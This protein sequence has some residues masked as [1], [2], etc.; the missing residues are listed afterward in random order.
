VL[1]ACPRG[2]PAARIRVMLVHMPAQVFI[3][4]RRDD[5]AGHAGRLYEGLR[6]AYGEDN[7]FKDT[8]GSGL[9]PGTV[10]PDAL[11]RKLA[12][13][14]VVLCVIGPKWLRELKQRDASECDWVVAELEDA[15]Q[16]RKRVIPVLV[17]GAK[18]P[19][20]NELPFGIQ[21]L[22]RLEC[23]A[24]PPEDFGSKCDELVASLDTLL[25]TP[26]RARNPA[27]TPG[28]ARQLANPPPEQTIESL[29]A[30]LN[31]MSPP[32]ERSEF[33]PREQPVPERAP[34]RKSRSR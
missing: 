15:F 22:A 18:M 2:L 11:H 1:L 28:V 24:L 21:E 19:R 30:K 4:Y 27:R 8:E 17:G 9:R 33:A 6:H 16:R 23:R 32:R 3:N 26:Q 29:L 31:G 14:E 20:A 12:E 13:C 5:D 7:V 25:G 10:F 34:R